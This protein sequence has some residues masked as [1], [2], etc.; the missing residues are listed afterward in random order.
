MIAALLGD[1]A[2][3]ALDQGEVLAVLAE[4]Q[5]GQPVIVEREHDLGCSAVARRRPVRAR[6]CRCPIVVRAIRLEPSVSIGSAPHRRFH[7]R[8]QTGCW[9]SA[10]VIF[11]AA[12][13]PIIVDGRHDL[14]R[15]EIWG[16]ADDLARMASRFFEQISK[17]RPTQ[18]ALNAAWWRSIAACRR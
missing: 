17:L 12:T 4:Q 18:L 8:R 15:L 3:P 13:S 6:G 7:E 2:E 11:T 14:N 9:Y 5:R 10:A 16:A 1:D